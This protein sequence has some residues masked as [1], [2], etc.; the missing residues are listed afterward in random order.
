MQA[1]VQQSGKRGREAGGGMEGVE[2]WEGAGGG[3][4]ERPGMSKQVAEGFLHKCNNAG[5]SNPITFPKVQEASHSAAL[6]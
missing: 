4:D 2:V 3:P 6:G 5:V 1:F